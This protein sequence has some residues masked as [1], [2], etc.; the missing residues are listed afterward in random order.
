MVSEIVLQSCF[1]DLLKLIE[2]NPGITYNQLMHITKY[3]CRT[4]DAA[5]RHLKKTKKVETFDLKGLTA[6]GLRLTH[7]HSIV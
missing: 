7:E 1:N 2:Q 3:K 4:L 6:K 5:I